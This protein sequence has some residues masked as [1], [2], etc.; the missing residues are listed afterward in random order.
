MG[1]SVTKDGYMAC[2]SE[3]NAVYLYHSSLPLPITRHGFADGQAGA[4]EPQSGHTFAS[5]VC[6]SHAGHHLIA[7]NSAGCMQV[8]QLA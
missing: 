7:A 4:A 2:G 3:D 6:W 5:S 1:L 8:L